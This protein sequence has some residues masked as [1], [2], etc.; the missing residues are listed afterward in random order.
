MQLLPGIGVVG[1]GKENACSMETCKSAKARRQGVETS[2]RSR[3]K[4]REA[5]R[6][7]GGPALSQSGGQH[8]RCIQELQE[9][10]GQDEICKEAIGK[11]DCQKIG[12]DEKIRQEKISEEACRTQP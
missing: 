8:A 12:E 7:A 4:L 11:K 1:D 6:H 9:E 10:K 2:E 3:Q 5:T